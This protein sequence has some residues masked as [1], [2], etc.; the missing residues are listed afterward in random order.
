T[1]N[2]AG[3]INGATTFTS[4]ENLTG[5]AA[6]DTFKFS[7]GVPLSGVIDG[8]AGSD[9]IDWSAY[10]TARTVALTGPG[11]IDGFMGTEASIAGGFVNIDGVV[12]SGTNADTLNGLDADATWTVNAASTYDSGG[13]TLTFGGFETLNGGSAVD[14]FTIQTV[15]FA[16]TAN[17]NDGNDIFNVGSGNSLGGI[18]AALT[19]N[20]GNNAAT[21][22]TTLTVGG[23]SNTLPTGDIVNFNDQGAAGS[24]YTL[25]DTTFQRTGIALISYATV[26]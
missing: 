19:I 21:P 8:A 16:L 22:T 1:A 25:T 5:G 20:G 13:G 14:T 26:E 9:T 18:S 12:G 15:S 7:D 24:A 17:G 2:N 11:P 4:F 10:T 6:D 3:N 23:V